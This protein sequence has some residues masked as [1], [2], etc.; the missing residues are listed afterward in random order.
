M[1]CV[2]FLARGPKYRMRPVQRRAPRMQD[3]TAA[4]Y[5]VHMVDGALWEF[6]KTQEAL[7][8]YPPH[9]FLAWSCAI[10]EAAEAAARPLGLGG[11]R[12]FEVAIGADRLVGQGSSRDE[13]ADAPVC[14]S[15]RRQ[16]DRRPHFHVP[17]ALGRHIPFFGE[18]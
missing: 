8:G 15:T 16:G 6:A 10:Q 14:G 18:N 12:G 1:G 17:K 3:P 7:Y 9:I 4:D 13:T 2:R 5:M 11:G